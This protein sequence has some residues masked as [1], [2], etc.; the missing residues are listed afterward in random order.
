[1]DI[2]FS[3]ILQKRERKRLNR[4]IILYL[5]GHRSIVIN[6]NTGSP[7]DL[8]NSNIWSPNTSIMVQSNVRH[9]PGLW[10]AKPT[11]QKHSASLWLLELISC[12]NLSKRGRALP[13]PTLHD[14]IKTQTFR[15]NGQKSWCG[16]GQYHVSSRRTI[17]ISPVNSYRSPW[18]ALCSPSV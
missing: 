9:P 2:Y 3:L 12:A 8:T 13:I 16:V 10:K 1:M 15:S 7:V 6:S 11:G 14:K 18:D 17:A 4:P 5:G